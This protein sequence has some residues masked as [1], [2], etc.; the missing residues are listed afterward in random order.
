MSAYAVHYS[1]LIGTG[2][3]F[4]LIEA[5]EGQGNAWPEVARKL[6]DRRRGI[7]SDGLLVLD[8]SKRADVR[9]RIFNPDGSEPSMCGNGVRCLAWYAHRYKGAGLRFSVETRAGILRV[10]ILGVRRVRVDMGRPVLKKRLL[11]IRVGQGPL[12]EGAL[13]HSGVPH[14][15]VWVDRLKG[16]NVNRVGRRLRRDRRLGSAGANVD[17]VVLQKMKDHEGRRLSLSMRTYE[18]GVEAETQACGT[19]AVA[20]AAAVVLEAAGD[21][22]RIQPVEVAVKVSGGRLNVMVGIS[23]GT[24]NRPIFSHAFLEGEARQVSQGTVMLNGR[25]MG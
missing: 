13:I 19:G 3:D 16:L 5:K 14:L 20:A 6:C 15:V 1:K 7:G 23:G 8:D 17:F 18:R 2:N 11:G 22:R 10:Q 21:R 25:K 4:V 12:T 9:M 24:K